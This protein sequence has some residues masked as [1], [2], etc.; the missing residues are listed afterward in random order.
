MR[1][2]A[3]YLSLGWLK[4]THRMCYTHTFC[5]YRDIWQSNR[6]RG[7]KELCICSGKLYL[8]K[9]ECT[10]LVAAQNANLDHAQW[11]SVSTRT[12]FT[13]KCQYST[14]EHSKLTPYYKMWCALCSRRFH[15]SL[16]LHTHTRPHFSSGT[17]IPIHRT[18]PHRVPNFTRCF[19]FILP[20]WEYMRNSLYC[21][22]W[23]TQ[24]RENSGRSCEELF[25]LSIQRH[26]IWGDLGVALVQQIS[27]L[28]K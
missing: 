24:R 18:T 11:A 6:L 28:M 25:L 19:A 3:S 26:V 22:W 12:I 7:Q 2:D 13:I 8:I 14:E 27:F 10:T 15:H 21:R 1:A 17:R 20:Q 16:A 4:T 9:H 23:D 5:Q